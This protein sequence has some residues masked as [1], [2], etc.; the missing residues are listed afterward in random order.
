MFSDELNDILEKI[1]DLNNLADGDI[2]INYKGNKKF[3]NKNDIDK[4]NGYNL[5]SDKYKIKIKLLHHHLM[6]ELFQMQ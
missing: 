5:I 6:Q 4:V 1:N 3:V 2:I